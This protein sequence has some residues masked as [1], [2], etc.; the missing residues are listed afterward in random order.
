MGHATSAYTAGNGEPQEM[1][2]Q[3]SV[4]TLHSCSSSNNFL[5][6][7]IDCDG[8][9]QHHIKVCCGRRL[10]RRVTAS[11]FLSQWSES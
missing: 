9:G 2:V 11:G 8:R 3:H 5:D 4:Q 10:T 1:G 6:D 7:A